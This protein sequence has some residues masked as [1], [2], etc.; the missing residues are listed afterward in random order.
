MK[1]ETE[2]FLAFRY[3][4]SNRQVNL[5]ANESTTSLSITV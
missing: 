5:I 2:N 4:N 3:S 1:E